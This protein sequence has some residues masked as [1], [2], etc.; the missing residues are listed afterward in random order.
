MR[1]EDVPSLAAR[2]GVQ[3]RET[4]QAL[5]AR[6]DWIGDA[7]GMGL[8]QA[9][10]LVRDKESAEPDPVRARALLEAARE[11]GLLIGLG[12]MHGHV[13][14]LGPSLLITEDEAAEAL[15]RLERACARV[16]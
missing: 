5:A 4:L 8:M 11:E 3:V 1:E 7:R 16:A 12:G 15:A 13:M 2:R 9:L 10:E 6:Y 14:R